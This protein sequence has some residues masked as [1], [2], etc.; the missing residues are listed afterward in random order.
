MEP[1]ALDE[2]M[3]L[4]RSGNQIGGITAGVKI[5]NRG[6]NL[7]TRLCSTR[8]WFAFNIERACQSIWGCVSCLSG[9]I[10]LYRACDLDT[11]L[12]P[13]NLQV[14]G[15]KHTTF[16]DDRHLTNQLLGH[17]LHCRYTHRT[18]C[19]SESP[20]TFVR[21]I[22]QQTR[23]TKSFFREAFWFP[24]SFAYHHPWMFLEMTIHTLYPFFLLSTCFHLLFDPSE[25]HKL[26]PVVWLITIFGLAFV[27]SLVA[28][29]IEFD[30][31]LLLF[32]LYGF[33]HFFGL[34]PTK[35]WA[36]VTLNSTGW[37][38]GARSATER[39]KHQT[40]A[41]RSFLIGHLVVW[42]GIVFTGIGY[43][44]YRLFD[45]P[46]L[47]LIT[48]AMVIMTIYLYW[49]P[50]KFSDKF[51]ELREKGPAWMRKRKSASAPEHGAVEIV[52][53]SPDTLSEKPKAPLVKEEPITITSVLPSPTASIKD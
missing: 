47:L 23:W 37:G 7:L 32:A 5:W 2:M 13:W 49:D 39:K 12:G 45:N 36:L 33:I 3:A 52:G 11:I 28:L 6:D 27:K 22:T 19:D 29:V 48:V 43:F 20:K 50:D 41:Q 51:Q 35:L 21:W 17:G 42:F 24:K 44:V 30:P 40:F 31:W 25:G 46:L 4:M 16:G 53:D 14:F 26:R 38:T 18:W 15:G 9:P 10:A 1:N 8:Y 34:L